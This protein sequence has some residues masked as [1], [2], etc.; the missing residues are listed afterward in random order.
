MSET[1]RPGLVFMALAG[2]WLL[3]GCGVIARK[4][5]LTGTRLFAEGQVSR[6]INEF[7]TALA[8]DNRNADAWYNLGA[9]YYALGKQSNH[10]PWIDQAETLFRQAISLNEQHIAAH[11]SLA[12]LLV[13][14]GRDRYAFDLLHTWQR[15]QPQL[16][17]P[18]VELA[19]LHQEFGDVT[20]AA[21]YLADAMRID[22]NNPR[23]LKAMGHVRESQ[24]QLALALDNYARSYQLDSRQMDVAT[25]INEIQQRLAS[26]SNPG[27]P[28]TNPLIQPGTI[29]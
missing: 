10:R 1:C 25:R 13:E 26:T 23:I 29:R 8:R 5:N 28:N 19:R 9:T 12:A 2:L 15:R 6:A 27:W 7:Q 18:L 20:R 21:D 16:S 17:D 14:T 3:S 4:H 24:G 11:R 22:S